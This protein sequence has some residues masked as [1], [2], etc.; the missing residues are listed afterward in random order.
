MNAYNLQCAHSIQIII[1]AASNF[2]KF[3]FQNFKL[4][5]VTALLFAILNLGDN[6]SESFLFGYDGVSYALI[7]CVEE[8]NSHLVNFLVLY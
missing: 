1:V 4:G 6:P 7:R 8:V 2:K 3:Q 5:E